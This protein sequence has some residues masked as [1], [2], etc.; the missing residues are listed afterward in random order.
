[1]KTVYIIRH[2]KSD[3]S[4]DGQTDIDR[5]LNARGYNDA[6]NVGKAMK[7]KGQVPQVI[8]SSPAIRALLYDTDAHEYEKVLKSISNSA[9]SVA[10]FGHNP[11]VSDLSSFWAGKLVDMPTCA[12][13]QF[14]VL[15]DKWSHLSKENVQFVDLLVPKMI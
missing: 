11:V 6:H 3:W 4:I 2:A 1:M 13:V 14:R 12:V 5:A 7:G 15:T 9:G 8:I 10:I